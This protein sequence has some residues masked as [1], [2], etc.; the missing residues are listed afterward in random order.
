[1]ATLLVGETDDIVVNGIRYHRRQAAALQTTRD[2]LIIIFPGTRFH[3]NHGGGTGRLG[4]APTRRML[5][6]YSFNAWSTGDV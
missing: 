6:E 1:M 4:Y 5:T 2:I 3:T